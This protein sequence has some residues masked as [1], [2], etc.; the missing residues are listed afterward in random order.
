[1]GQEEFYGE[2]YGHTQSSSEPVSQQYYSDGHGEYSYQQSSYGEQNYERSFD[3]LSQHYYEGGN[4]QYSQQQTQYQQGSG[5]HQ[6]FS[7]HLYPSQAGY[8]AQPQGY[9]AGQGSSSQYPQY[10]QGQS[11]QYPSY[12]SIQPGPAAPSQR[13]YSFEQVNTMTVLY[14][15]K[16]TQPSNERGQYGNYQQ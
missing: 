9:G 5:T 13:S 6:T 12:R 14:N 8:S 1:M 3:E 7:Q 10:Q 16:V 11:Q 4:S 2:Q 15:D